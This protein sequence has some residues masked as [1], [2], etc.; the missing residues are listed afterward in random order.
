ML[1]NSARA[2]SNRKRCTKEQPFIV[3]GTQRSSLSSV[4]HL[5][6]HE[7]VLRWL[8]F[9]R[10][11]V[12][13]TMHPAWG[14]LCTKATALMS[15]ACCQARFTFLSLVDIPSKAARLV[16]RY[17]RTHRTSRESSN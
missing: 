7:Q 2:D 3:I 16:P 13:P 9:R 15:E 1:S 5:M 11:I 4:A 14:D 8:S 17:R 6:H 12:R 10:L